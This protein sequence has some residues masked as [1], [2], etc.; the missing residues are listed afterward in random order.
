MDNPFLYS[1]FILIII[2][3]VV[4][5][6]LRTFEFGSYLI[7]KT[8]DEN[9]ELNFMSPLNVIWLISIISFG[10]SFGDYYPKNIITRLI[11]FFAIIILYVIAGFLLN[12]LMKYTI[13][14]E[15]EKKVFIKMTKLYSEENLE[16]KA[17]Y[18][19][20][21]ILKL[22]RDKML[23]NAQENQYIRVSYCKKVSINIL[24]LNRHIKNF[25]N[26]DKVADVFTIPV[27]DLLISL[28]NKIH[29]NL[30][31][32]EKSFD[33]LESIQ[34]DLEEIQELQLLINSNI[35]ENIT[36]QK[37]I[38][39]YMVEINNLGLVN[40]LKTKIFKKKTFMRFSEDL[41]LN[42][43][44]LIKHVSETLNSSILKNRKKIKSNFQQ[45]KKRKRIAIINTKITEKEG[46]DENLL[47]SSQRGKLIKT[48]INYKRQKSKKEYSN[49]SKNVF[50]DFFNS[51]INKG[52]SEMNLHKI[53]FKK[54]KE[55]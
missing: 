15:S 43:A 39:K 6:L 2:I 41:S 52:I 17:T 10:V 27:D 9:K 49:T 26:N 37:S 29:E 19:I 36:Q 38:G 11:V 50:S 34:N 40:Q 51:T 13:M 31:N 8:R 7:Y 18:V 21:Q 3:S 44:L 55:E 54:E 25:Q 33:K 24:I 48:N 35:R 46:D 14:S 47:L 28:E 53:L 32:F 12:N 20:L 23:L 5:F 4:V 45:K 22:R 16:Y 1:L 30:L 42:D